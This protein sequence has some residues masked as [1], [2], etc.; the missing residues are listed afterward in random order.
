M[1]GILDRLAAAEY[2]PDLEDIKTK[3]VFKGFKKSHVACGTNDAN[4]SGPPFWYHDTQEI[5]DYY[6]MMGL[7]GFVY[8][9]LFWANVAHMRWQYVDM[10]MLFNSG[11]EDR[12]N[13]S[14]P[15]YKWNASDPIVER[16]YKDPVEIVPFEALLCR[17]HLI[18]LTAGITVWL[19]V[20]LSVAIH[21]FLISSGIYP[22]E[23]IKMVDRTSD[24][25]WVPR[26]NNHPGLHEVSIHETKPRPFCFT[27]PITNIRD[28]N[29]LYCHHEL[30]ED[31]VFGDT[32]PEKM[33]TM[34]EKFKK[35]MFRS[36]PPSIGDGLDWL[37]AQRAM[38]DTGFRILD[39][40]L[41]PGRYYIDEDVPPRDD[42]IM[43]GKEL[44]RLVWW[45]L[46]PQTFVCTAVQNVRFF[47]G[48]KTPTSIYSLIGDYLGLVMSLAIFWVQ[49]SKWGAKKLESWDRNRD[50]TQNV[51]SK[52]A[53]HES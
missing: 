12:K 44:R 24:C 11:F 28:G 40:F 9:M 14:E 34:R 10:N 4:E 53:S 33:K 29:C 3:T 27:A 42:D 47:A 32:V 13:P 30:I 5:L 20:A 7:Y 8:M 43:R 25:P 39:K 6:K 19:L 15:N 16:R 2:Y 49:Y 23:T 1:G 21:Q 37:V 48:L 26:H 45:L 50:E 35:K 38:Y 52:K 31:A 51:F 17:V 18:S 46:W 36:Y 22:V 41:Y